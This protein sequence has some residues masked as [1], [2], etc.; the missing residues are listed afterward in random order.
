MRATDADVQAIS[1]TGQNTMPY[2]LTA[3][4]LVDAYL[5]TSA[6]APAL[7]F[8]I[9]RWLAAHLQALAHGSGG[10]VTQ[11]KI[12]ELTLSYTPS[13]LGT[14]LA[15]TRFG[16]MVLALDPTGALGNVGA[17]RALLKVD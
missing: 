8:E 16:Q 9:E 5:G 14:G 12:G 1:P 15:S 13:Q 2:L 17:K 10:G 7:L 6:L 3:T 4:T 11:R